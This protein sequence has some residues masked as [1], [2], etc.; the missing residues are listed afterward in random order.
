MPDNLKPFIRPGLN[1]TQ[2]NKAL[3]DAFQ[4][5]KNALYAIFFHWCQNC[6]AAGEGWV[7]HSLA[8]CRQAGDPCTL[9]CPQCG[10]GQPK[11]EVIRRGA[12]QGATADRFHVVT[13]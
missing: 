1:V 8:A 13:V 12:Y 3:R 10:N 5:D 2:A 7:G 6:W 9:Q 4:A 11:E